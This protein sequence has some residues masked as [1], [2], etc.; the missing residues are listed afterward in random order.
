VSYNRRVT[1]PPI[2][3]N[4]GPRSSACG[5]RGQGTLWRGVSID[6]GTRGCPH[7]K[8]EVKIKLG[9]HLLQPIDGGVV[10]S[11]LGHVCDVFVRLDRRTWTIGPELSPL[12]FWFLYYTDGSFSFRILLG[13]WEFKV[14]SSKFKLLY[15]VSY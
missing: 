7:V 10:L 12:K 3:V 1:D 14:V 13:R 5:L 4:K 6:G 15:K 2:P 9:C 8:D 11:Y